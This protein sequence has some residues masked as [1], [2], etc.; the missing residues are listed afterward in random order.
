MA[1]LAVALWGTA[2]AWLSSLVG[3]QLFIGLLRDGF[4]W[5]GLGEQVVGCLVGFGTVSLVWVAAACLFLRRRARGAGIPLTAEALEERQ[6]LGLRPAPGA[7]GRHE[8][9]LGELR[10]ADRAALVAERGEEEV[11]FRWRLGRAGRSVWGSLTFDSASAAVLLDIREEEG[12]TGVAGLRKGT[13]FLAVC[14]IARAL[15]LVAAGEQDE[16]GGPNLPLS[17]GG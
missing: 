5:G 3:T 17:Y 8:R 7:D 15:G 11:W 14:Q 1:R 16:P 9:I 13:A 6:V 2:L 10:A 4:S 12:G